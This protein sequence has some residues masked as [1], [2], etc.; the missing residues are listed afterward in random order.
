MESTRS[1]VLVVEDDLGLQ[2]QLKWA[3][4][5]FEVISAGTREEAIAELRRHSPAIVLQDLGLPPDADGVE[6]GFRTIAEIQSLAPQTKII[7]ITGREGREHALRAI[8]SGA[9]DFCQKPIDTAMLALVVG[10]ALR[11]H[12]LESEVQRLSA[13]RPVT[14]LE[15]VVAASASMLKACRMIER[16][17]PTDAT[18]LLL[19]ESGTGKERLARAVHML[20]PRAAKPMIAINCAAIP[21]NLLESELFGYERGAFTGAVKRTLGK[22]ESADGGTLFL[23]EIGDMPMALQAKMLRFLQERVI[24]RVG[25]REVIAVDVRIV[26]ATHRDLEL[27]IQQGTMRSDLFYR[28][29]EIS[30]RIPPLRERESDAVLIANHLLRKAATR[31][32]RSALKFAPDAIAAIERHAW[33][34]NVRELENRINAASIMTDGTTVSSA[35]LGLQA[36]APDASEPL[37]LAEVRMRAESR[38]VS[39]ALAIAAGNTSKAAELLGV[40]PA[41]LAE[42]M[43]RHVLTAADVAS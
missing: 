43:K 16:L 5:S 2:R 39:R 7:V 25:G 10:R 21:E 31:N 17:A 38:A 41:A 40:T 36:T 32:G 29:S 13:A 12:E 24:E 20:S 42:L 3:L 15:G 30:V 8:S 37:D 28:I 22:V 34:G 6:E 4:D 19:G 9:F 26:A 11:I 1:K 14:A 33:P 18:V 23:D 27:A 35:D